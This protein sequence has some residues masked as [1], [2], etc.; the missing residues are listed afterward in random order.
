MRSRRRWLFVHD[1]GLYKTN[2]ALSS[3]RPYALHAYTC[4]LD[5]NYPCV[6]QAQVAFIGSSNRKGRAIWNHNRAHVTIMP[7]RISPPAVAMNSKAECQ[8]SYNRRMAEW[9]ELVR[10]TCH[11]VAL[12]GT[13]HSHKRWM[14]SPHCIISIQACVTTPIRPP[15][16]Q[17]VIS[18]LYSVHTHIQLSSLHASF[19]APLPTCPNL[20]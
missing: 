9:L 3:F 8:G 17:V 1:L 4:I 10:L 2:H 5:L 15:V 18:S 19:D 14:G 12:V 13:Q 11:L 7:H 16:Y 20:T 6:Q